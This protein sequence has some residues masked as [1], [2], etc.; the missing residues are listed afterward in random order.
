MPLAVV[1]EF[2]LLIGDSRFVVGS[3]RSFEDG[4]YEIETRFGP[5]RVPV[6][7]VTRIDI[8][9]T[10]ALDIEKAAAVANPGLG[11]GL[12][13]GQ[14][15]FAGSNAI[16]ETLVPALLQGYATRGRALD[17]LWVRG[18][19]PHEQSLVTVAPDSK[20]FVASINRSGTASALEALADDSADIGMMSRQLSPEEAQ[21]IAVRL[22]HPSTK[23]QEHVVALGGVVVLVHPSNPVKALRLDQIADI[24]PV[25]SATGA[26]SAVQLAAFVSLL[27][28]K[29][30]GSSMCFAL[31]FCADVQSTR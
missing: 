13:G 29:V 21:R 11:A 20:K 8:A 16:G 28:Q 26:R 19:T 27:H 2:Q 23:I 4:I 15:R 6:A 25:A 31:G 1:P 7:E 24:F 9:W 5:I 17:T 22:G 10:S 12:T 14:L 3:M 18:A 30:P